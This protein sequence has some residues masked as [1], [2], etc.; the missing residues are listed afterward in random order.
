MTSRITETSFSEILK[1][2]IYSFRAHFHLVHTLNIILSN[3][4]KIFPSWQL[5]PLVKCCPFFVLV[6]FALRASVEMTKGEVHSFMVE[7][8]KKRIVYFS[9]S[10]PHKSLPSSP[11][12]HLSTPLSFPARFHQLISILRPWSH[13]I[14]F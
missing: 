7:D 12:C 3:R 9:S 8:N 5:A 2:A 1:F 6:H 13:R 11:T 4:R 14:P 10:T